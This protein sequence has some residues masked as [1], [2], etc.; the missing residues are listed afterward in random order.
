MARNEQG[1]PELAEARAGGGCGRDSER[2]GEASRAE[3]RRRE[4]G[5]PVHASI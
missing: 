3:E 1:L 4:A 2:W 5:G